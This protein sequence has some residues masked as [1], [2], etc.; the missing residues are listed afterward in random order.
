VLRAVV[1]QDAKNGEVRLETKDLQKYS[2]N[3]VLKER[4]MAREYIGSMD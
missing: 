4:Y 3:E 2:W 1:Y